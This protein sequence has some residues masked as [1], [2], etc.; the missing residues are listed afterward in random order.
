MASEHT[1]KITYGGRN[2]E[3]ILIIPDE[4][5]TQLCREINGNFVLIPKK[6]YDQVGMLDP[7]FPH[8]IGDFDYGLRV[9]SSGFDCR[10]TV[11]LY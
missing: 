9:A 3:G 4:T 2:K 5:T 7:V 10:I 1:G 11:P 6:I 8:A